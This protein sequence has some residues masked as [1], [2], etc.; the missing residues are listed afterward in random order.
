MSDPSIERAWKA[1]TAVDS[2]LRGDFVSMLERSATVEPS[3]WTV[4]HE[5]ARILNEEELS[6]PRDVYNLWC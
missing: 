2:W 4:V 3:Q 1:L 5:A 6:L